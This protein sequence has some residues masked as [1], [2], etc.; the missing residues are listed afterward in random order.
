M[1]VRGRYVETERKAPVK[2]PYSGETVGYVCLATS[3]DVLESARSASQYG[4]SLSAYERYKILSGTAHEIVSDAAG[5]ALSIC[6][7]S[8]MCLKD[9]AKEVKRAATILTVCAE[10]AKRITG[11]SI[12]TDTTDGGQDNLAV[13]IREPVG[14]VCAITPFNRPLN[15]VVVKLGPAIAANN[16]VILKP[17]EKTPLTAFKFLDTLLRNGLPPEMVTVVTGNPEEIGEALVTS[18]EI[19]MITF[20]GSAAV[21]ERIAR[22][23]G[24]IRMTFEL[25]DS[26][27]LIVMQDAD[28]DKAVKTAAA[29]AY[30]TAGQSCRG[31]KRMLVHKDVAAEFTEKL[32]TASAKIKCGDPM[33]PGTDMGVLINE[34]SAVLVEKR[35]RDAVSKGAEVV[36]GGKREGAGIMP[37]VLV[38]VPRDADLVRK[39]TFGPCAPI[40]VVDDMDDAV[41]YTNATEYG[42]QTGIFTRDIDMAMLAARKLKVGAVIINN[43]PQFESPNI[44][45]GGVK[46]SGLG[47]EGIKYA[48]QEMTTVKT[49]VF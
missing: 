33:D 36:Y 32:C 31:I 7:E 38:G 27:A 45:F 28:L 25:G 13:T 20:T 47:R 34:E 16:S 8:G 48:I 12:F 19:D 9:A 29:G 15:Q 43:G 30:S 42:L 41:E 40:I 3:A 18:P 23:A 10:E 44:P 1:F 6:R 49:I 17:S 5:F 24:M 37:T 21:G 4:S 22:A 26:G 39:E 11:E 46:K 14:L 2:N 35:I